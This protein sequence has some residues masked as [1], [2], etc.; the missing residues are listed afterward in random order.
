MPT[1]VKIAAEM[2]EAGAH[3]L[4]DLYDLVSPGLAAIVAE[5]VFSAMTVS[6]KAPSEKRRSSDAVL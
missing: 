4:A 3:V 6:R 5:E 1:G 2:K